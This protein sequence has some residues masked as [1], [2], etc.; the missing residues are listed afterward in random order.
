MIKYFFNSFDYDR[1]SF[2]SFIFFFGLFNEVEEMMTP[3]T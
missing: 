1:W 3:L 2:L